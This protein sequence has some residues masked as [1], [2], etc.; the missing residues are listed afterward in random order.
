MTGARPAGDHARSRRPPPN[1]APPPTELVSTMRGSMVPADVYDAGAAGARRVPQVQGQVANR[2]RPGRWRGPKTA[3]PAWRSA[4]SCCCRWPRSRSRKFFLHAAIPG[5]AADRVGADAVA[6]HARRR[7]RGARRQAAHARHRRVPARRDA[8]S[9]VAHV[10]AGAV[11]AHDR[12]DRSRWAAIALVQSDRA[13]GDMLTAGGADVDRRSRA[14]DR[15]RAD[16]GRAS[17]GARRR[18]WAGRAARRARHRRAASCS[19]ISTA[20]R[21][22]GQSLLPWLVARP[23]RGRRSARR[24]S[25]CSAASRCSPR[26][27]AAIRRSCCR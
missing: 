11:G 7:D 23:R 21:S 13:A 9:A 20:T 17:S 15:L 27:R 24:S 25:R 6:R 1:S 4:G 22:R 18:T 10:F 2:P 8:I 5:A 3:S 26:S 14:A 12:D 19:T 16:R